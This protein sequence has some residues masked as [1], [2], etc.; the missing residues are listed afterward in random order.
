[1]LWI[2]C[3]K[4]LPSNRA[5]V[6]VLSI[7][8]VLAYYWSIYSE[9][10]VLHRDRYLS[11]YV[12]LN[13][14]NHFSV[15]DTCN[16][17]VFNHLHPSLLPFHHPDYNPK[18][19]CTPY[20]P[21]TSLSNGRIHLAEKAKDFR[22]KARCVF[23][24][25]ERRYSLGNWIKLPSPEVF[26]CDVIETLCENGMHNQEA[27][28]HSQIHE[29]QTPKPVRSQRP[30]VYLIII[31][32]VSSFMAKRSLPKTIKFIRD[33]MEGT[34][35]E[36]LN[37][38][39]VNSRPNGFPLVF[40]KSI[41][42]G[43]RALIGLPALK[44]DWNRR[45]MC[46]Q[47]LD[48]YDYH[49]HQFE[50]HGYKSMIAQDENVGI[51]YYPDCLGFNRSEAN[52]VWRPFQLRM[53]ESRNLHNSMERSCNERHIEMLDYLGKFIH[54]YPVA[55]KTALCGSQKPVSYWYSSGENVP[56]RNYA[57][58]SAPHPNSL[59]MPFKVDP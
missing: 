16:L 34:L 56:K 46:R 35:M 52:H 22:C 48:N 18:A 45:T 29:Q 25:T 9:P 43:N 36:F 27:F 21:F 33:E 11:K 40:G 37:K 24:V 2:S 13:V 4:L 10:R 39:G 55:N 7:I 20:K 12:E 15:F 23:H 30:D 44:P 6:Y 8:C 42:G 5:I 28:L 50:A 1:M 57:W 17:T 32:S 49:L 53:R 31:D 47:Y 51:A 59:Q 3:L 58:T 19:G 54:S 38:V 41:E 26:P 14:T